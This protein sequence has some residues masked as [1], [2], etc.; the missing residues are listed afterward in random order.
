L[1]YL[2]SNISLRTICDSLLLAVPAAGLPPDVLALFITVVVPPEAWPVLL[3]ADCLP[4]LQAA[5]RQT[6]GRINNN[7]I[8]KTIFYKNPK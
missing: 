3:P 4:V 5:N 8:K 1:G 2:A 7:L 6:S